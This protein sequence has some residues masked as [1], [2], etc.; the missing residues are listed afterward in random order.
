MVHKQIWKKKK[1]SLAEQ[2]FALKKAYKESTCFIQ[3]HN[4]LIWRGQACPSPLSSTYSL[5]IR[6]TLGS[7]PIVTVHGD[8]IK[9]IEAP[10][11]PHVFH[12]DV[13]SNTVTLCLCYGDEFN[14]SMLISDTYIPWAIEWLYYYEIW[15]VTEEWCGGGIH[16][17]SKK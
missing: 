16:P 15:L 4:T 11:F 2:L 7:K 1:I 13:N 3:G 9:N 5:E 10:N 12:R 8:T 14:S 17:F 6:Y